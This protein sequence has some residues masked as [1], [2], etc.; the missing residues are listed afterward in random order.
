MNRWSSVSLCIA[1]L[2]LS[3]VPLQAQQASGGVQDV[4][5]AYPDSSEG[6]QKM[7]HET[8]EAVKSRDPT[9]E[10]TLIHTLIMP[11][12]AMW[13]KDEFG[14]SFGPRLAV[15]YQ[16]ITPELEQQ[17]Q[18]VYEGNAQRG[19]SQPKIFR[20]ADAATVGSPIDNF[21]NCMDVVVPLYQTAFNGDRP[22]SQV[23]VNVNTPGS[24]VVAGDLP[25][26]YVYAKGGFRFVPQAIFSL[27]P[28]ERP[29]RI[30]LD[31]N[32][33]RSKIINNVQWKYPEEAIRQHIKGK[34][35]IHFVLDTNGK[36]KE[37]SAAEGPRILSDPVLQAVRQW[38]FEPTTLDG[39]PVEVEINLETGF[40]INGNY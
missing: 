31:M 4:E 5:A 13:F 26:Y 22:G 2:L 40:Q 33:M 24:K 19:W 15:A 39:E 35:V 1:A 10:A 16:K 36:I 12:D 23:A 21:L 11:E 3:P 37:I 9:K 7:L 29:I 25:G 38:T 8:I 17:I 20:Y 32:V 30:Q 27:L 18:T 28:K 14:P 6:L 34:V